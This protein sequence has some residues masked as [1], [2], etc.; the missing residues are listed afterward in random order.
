MDM[1]IS[2]EV[3]EQLAQVKEWMES[4]TGREVTFD[5]V[6]LEILKQFR[7][8]VYPEDLGSA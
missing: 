3:Y 1:K 6:L 4:K 5:D 8:V 7:T 2:E